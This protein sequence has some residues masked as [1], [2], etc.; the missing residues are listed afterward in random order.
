MQIKFT[1]KL[2]DNKTLRFIDII[3]TDNGMDND[4]RATMIYIPTQRE[5]VTIDYTRGIDT[6]LVVGI[7]YVAN[8]YIRQASTVLID[9]NNEY[10]NRYYHFTDASNNYYNFNDVVPFEKYEEYSNFIYKLI[11]VMDRYS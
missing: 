6:D 7:R 10:G 2:H 9:F 8:S 11:S 4:K 3:T 5:Y 1:K